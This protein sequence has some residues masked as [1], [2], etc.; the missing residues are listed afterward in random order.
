MEFLLFLFCF[1]LLLAVQYPLFCFSLPHLKGLMLFLFVA[2][3]T[4]EAP[5]CFASHRLFI[6]YIFFCL[7]WQLWRW[8]SNPRRWY[9]GI[10][11]TWDIIRNHPHTIVGTSA[12]TQAIYC[13]YLSSLLNFFALILV[14]LFTGGSASG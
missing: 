14:L 6:V 1:L 10:N 13:F 11:D 9:I 5:F 4:V 3:M 12:T 2:T 7:H 8:H